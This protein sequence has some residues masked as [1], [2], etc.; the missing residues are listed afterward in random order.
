MRLTADHDALDV[1]N[2]VRSMDLSVDESDTDDVRVA[3]W[4]HL[5][6]SRLVPG[7]LSVSVFP[8]ATHTTA[9]V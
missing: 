4:L 8:H 2:K 3:D 5:S 7:V 9:L 1:A 6:R